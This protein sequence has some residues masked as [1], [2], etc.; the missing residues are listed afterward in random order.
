MAKLVLFD[1]DGTLMEESPT[2]TASFDYVCKQI[3]GVDTDIKSFPRHG[4]TD[5]GIM[6]GLLKKHSIPEAEIKNKLDTAFQAM[7]NY[8]STNIQPADYKLLDNVKNMLDAL[9]VN[10]FISGILTGNIKPIAE[11]RLKHAGI[12]NYFVTGGYGSDDIIRSKLVDYAIK[13]YGKDINRS[14]IY[15]IGDTPLDIKAAREASTKA[16]GVATGIYPI[17]DLSSADLV[18]KN[19]KDINKLIDFL[20]N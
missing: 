6:Y 12:E 9:K 17:T 19:F 15:L 13:R 7:V 11:I 3:Y 10:G 4:M 18:L 8:V 2:H 1:I 16:I 5:I 20:T 14:E